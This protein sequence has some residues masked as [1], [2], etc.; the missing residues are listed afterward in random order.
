M[1]NDMAGYMSIVMNVFFVYMLRKVM[2]AATQPIPHLYMLWPLVLLVAGT[3]GIT[4]YYLRQFQRAAKGEG[5]EDS[6]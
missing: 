1:L 4:F 5:D 2:Q 3:L 6:I